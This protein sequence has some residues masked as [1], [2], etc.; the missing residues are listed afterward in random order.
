MLAVL[1]LLINFSTAE[2]QYSVGLVFDSK[3]NISFQAGIEASFGSR[4]HYDIDSASVGDIVIVTDIQGNTT[5]CDSIAEDLTDKIA[6]I[7]RGT[8][9]FVQKCLN[10]AKKG[11]I[12]ILVANNAAGIGSMGA[13]TDPAIIALSKQITVPCLMITQGDGLALKDIINNSSPVIGGFWHPNNYS[14]DAYEIQSGKTYYKTALEEH[15]FADPS[16]DFFPLIGAVDSLN[17]KDAAFFLYAPTKSGAISVSSCNGNGNT[18]LNVY[19]SDLRVAFLR[20]GEFNEKWSNEGA[21]KKNATDTNGEAAVLNNIP[22]QGGK[23]YYI[24]FDDKNSKD[25]FFF[26]LNFVK[27]DS[28]DVTF[29]VDMKAEA[30]ID[31]AGVYIAGNFQGWDPAKTKLNNVTGTAIYE[32]TIRVAADQTIQ[33]KFINGNAWGKDESVTGSCAAPTDGNRK[34]EIKTEDITFVNPPCFKSCEVCITP[35]ADLTC[36]A[37]AIIC[38]PF[39]SYP[40]GALAK[41]TAAH[42]SV[43][44]D[45]YVNA[46]PVYVSSNEFNSD[47]KAMLIDFNTVKPQQDAILKLGNADKG[48]YNLNWKMFVPTKTVGTKKSSFAYYNIQHD[49]TGNHIWAADFFF[50]SN[51]AGQVQIGSTIVGTFTYTP[52]SWLDISHDIDIDKDTA[53]ITV[54]T[55]KVGWKWS[56]ASAGTTPTTNKV[57]AGVDFYALGD[58]CKYYIDDVQLIKFP[59]AKTKVTFSVDMANETVS[60]KGVCVAGNFQAAAGLG[61]DWTPGAAK[62]VN[63]PNT[64][65]WE[66]TVE[67]PLGKYEYKYIN[68][69]SWSNGKE[70]KNVGC[71]A[72]GENRQFELTTL[73]DKTLTTYCYNKCYVC[74]QRAVTFFLDLT[75]EA[76]VSPSQVSMAGNFQA[77]AGQGADW[78]PGVILLKRVAGRLYT[79]TLGIPAGTYEYKFING[80][81]WGKDEKVTGACA[82]A[83]ADGNRKLVVGSVDMKLDTVCFKYCVTCAKVVSTNDPKF[84]A[85]MKLYPNPSQD[86]VNLDY[87]FP[88]TVS[89]K[90]N[91]MNLLGQSVYVADMPE[92]SAGTA[93][94]DVHNL[95]NGTYMMQITDENNRQT[96]KR[97]VIER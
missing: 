88:A 53:I 23:Y 86:I 60:A 12:L 14:N 70:E 39:K 58:S 34:L 54:G 56:K 49:I 80:I 32:R 26:N 15:I 90:V 95:A 11:A 43:W 28:V 7:D 37:Q 21:C 22:V 19:E 91:V 41:G 93:I 82:A 79:T 87:E 16:D 38:D 10:A 57:M 62:L 1:A 24:E 5:A 52:D 47:T 18:N 9:G 85:A 59:D 81:A 83:G 72:G 33:Y 45:D 30:T 66:L 74:S 89:L 55:Q 78:T 75:K 35:K 64:T 51:K 25:S 48:H 4:L 71:D 61:N 92:V 65:I 6:L 73:T 44:D 8:C 17:A 20:D 29:A 46:G 97:F 96:V 40:N 50:L 68:D 2:A 69:D 27:R 94:L 42:W 67:L 84:D 36:D 77:A 76:T 13:G 31:P 3:F 63:K